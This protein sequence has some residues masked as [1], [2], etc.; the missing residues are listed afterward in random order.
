MAEPAEV[1]ARF[2]GSAED[3]VLSVLREHLAGPL[4]GNPHVKLIESTCTASGWDLYVY[5]DE[6]DLAVTRPVAAQI[7]RACDAVAETCPGTRMSSHVWELSKRVPPQEPSA[8][9]YTIYQR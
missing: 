8:G 5:V 4:A 1:R 9:W 7:G 2:Q 3:I 6:W